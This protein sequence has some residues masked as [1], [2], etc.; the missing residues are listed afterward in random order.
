MNG[1]N[2]HQ[3]NGKSLTASALNILAWLEVTRQRGSIILWNIAWRQ[4]GLE[5]RGLNCK[6]PLW[7]L[8]SFLS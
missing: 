3:E 5:R 2:F 7:A 8:F 6:P 1:F 4:A